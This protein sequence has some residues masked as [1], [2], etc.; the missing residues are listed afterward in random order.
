VRWRRSPIEESKAKMRDGR[1]LRS[2]GAK[3]CVVVITTLLF[4]FGLAEG[5]EPIADKPIGEIAFVSDRD[6][7]NEIYL[8]NSDGSD[9]R[10]LTN[11]PAE[12]M[13]PNWSPDGRQIAFLSARDNGRK[14]VDGPFHL[15]T[16]D[17]DGKN[18]HRL[19]GSLVAWSDFFW[20]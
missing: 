4:A 6:G 9:Q 14:G 7:N 8:M 12:D 11:N 5:R 17:A 18:V 19:S 3:I 15:Y 10:N 20:C 1:A 16:M 2:K 13:F